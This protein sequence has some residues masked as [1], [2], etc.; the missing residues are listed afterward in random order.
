MLALVDALKSA[1]P[2][3]VSRLLPAFEQSTNEVVGLRLIGA[4]KESKGLAGLNSGALKA[5]LEKYPQSV[6][7][8]STA[9]IAFLN[10][11]EAKQ[12]THLEELVATL[13]KGDIRGGQTLFNST[14]TACSSCHQIGYL[15]GKVGPNLSNIGSVRTERDLLEAIVYPSA[16][17][18]R[19]FEPFTA[20]TKS[21]DDYSGVLRKDSADEVILGTGPNSEVRLARADV[22]EMRPGKVSVM[23]SGLADQL[24]KQELADLIAFL[25][26][27]K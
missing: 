8:N 27:A 23:P 15:G 9:L 18:V 2:M 26:A 16:S 17:F 5:T 13:P 14:K 7:T 24:S 25:K 12:R 3:E 21:G 4:L 1:G 11:D 19:S 6:Q 10:V 20:I 22:V